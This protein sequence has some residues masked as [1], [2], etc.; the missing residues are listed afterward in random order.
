MQELA[1]SHGGAFWNEELALMMQ[2]VFPASPE[3]SASRQ[4]SSSDEKG[5]YRDLSE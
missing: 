5:F 4:G 1:G 2:W 3:R